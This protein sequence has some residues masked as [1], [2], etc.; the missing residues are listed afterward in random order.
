MSDSVKGQA[1]IE[2]LNKIRAEMK[3]IL[4]K[5]EREKVMNNEAIKKI[6]AEID[7]MA[8]K[9]LSEDQIK[10]NLIKEGKLKDAEIEWNKMD[11]EPG[12]FGKFLTNLVKMF[13][14][15]R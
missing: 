6:A 13:I 2:S 4:D 3:A 10:E 5:N 7:L 15:P 1:E 11:L 12:N 14:K 9:G 8:K